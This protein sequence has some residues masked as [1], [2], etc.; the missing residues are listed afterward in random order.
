M[1]FQ[2]FA[3]KLWIVPRLNKLQ[4][5]IRPA[6]PIISAIAIS[7]FPL[8]FLVAWII[9]SVTHELF[10]ILAI[11]VMKIG[12]LRIILDGNGTIIETESMLP[13][14]ELICA[15][16]GPFGG[17][18]LMLFA[19]AIPEAAI[20]ALIQ[21]AFNLLPYYPL[22]G[23][24]ALHCLMAM[25]AGEGSANRITAYINIITLVLLLTVFFYLQLHYRFGVTPLFII[26]LLFLK[27]I[28]NNFAL[29]TAQ[30]NSRI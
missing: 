11:C 20:C 22:D 6:F 4:F 2:H 26:L 18:L 19:R 10:H 17:M 23:G 27:S 8:K 7:V 9:A 1:L 12:I 25:L 24:R 13:Y 16:A 30:S 14:Q 21:S 28:K 3:M 15:L 5:N 29:Q